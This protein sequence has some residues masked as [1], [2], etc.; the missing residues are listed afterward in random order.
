VESGRDYQVVYNSLREGELVYIDR[1]YTFTDFPAYLRGATYIKTANED[2]FYTNDI[3]NES[4]FLGFYVNQ[5]VTVYIAYDNRYS[6][7]SW[8]LDNFLDT[9]DDLVTTDADTYFNVFLGDFSAG[10]VKLGINDANAMYI[11]VVV[12]R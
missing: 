9:G 10:E 4:D 7:P 1:S 8:L 5:D 6:A 12:G 3:R 2:K 11:V